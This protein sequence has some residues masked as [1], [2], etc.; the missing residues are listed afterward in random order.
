MSPSNAPLATSQALGIFFKERSRAIS[1]HCLKR[2]SERFLLD[3]SNSEFK[4]LKKLI[5]TGYYIPIAQEDNKIR[6]MTR[7][8]GRYIIFIVTDNYEKFITA[9]QCNKN[10][11]LYVEKFIKEFDL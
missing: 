6:I 10:D 11:I 4:R 2:L 8:K 1:E 5:K 3:L 9:L 7:Y